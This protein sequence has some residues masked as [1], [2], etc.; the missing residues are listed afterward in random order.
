MKLMDLKKEYK[1]IKG[2]EFIIFTAISD[3]LSDFEK[4]LVKKAS[5]FQD[6]KKIC[7]ENHSNLKFLKSLFSSDENAHRGL[8]EADVRWLCHVNSDSGGAVVKVGDF[9]ILI[10][11]GYGDRE[12]ICYLI[13][14]DANACH[15]MHYELYFKVGEGALILKTDSFEE[16]EAAAELPAGAYTAFSF[17]GNIYFLK[18]E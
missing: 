6:L 2:F 14:R 11:N 10:K 13:T 7:R 17:R 18:T 4:D 1:N 9:S 12:T 8:A 3:R 5:D 15:Y 16:A